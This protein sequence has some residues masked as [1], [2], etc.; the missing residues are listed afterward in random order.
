[1][2]QLSTTKCRTGHFHDSSARCVS[3]IECAF[4]FANERANNARLVRNAFEFVNERA[5]DARLVQNIP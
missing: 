2:S 3:A 4:E 1:M 5:D